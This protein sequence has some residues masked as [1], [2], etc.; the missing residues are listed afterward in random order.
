MAQRKVPLE[1]GRVYHI[2]SKSIAGFT[3]FR[4]N[5]EY[6]RIKYLLTYYNFTDLPWKFSRFFEME[7][8][9]KVHDNYFT[10]MEKLVD[11]IS[12]CIMPT[13]IHL[14]LKNLNQK[15]ISTFMRKILDSYAKYFNIKT[16]RK[17]PLWQSRFE[18]VLVET[19]E[20]LMH[21]TRYVH[22]NPVTAY[23]VDRPENWGFSS[24]K[25]FLDK[26]EEKDKICNYSNV[27]DIK[28]KEYEYFVNSQID[29]QR[30]LAGLKKLWIE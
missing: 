11:I 9:Q 22:L 16:K 26:E 13:H 7:D 14:V 6:Q 10:K 25:E 4:N 23:L 12:Y 17:G 5:S 27:L 15:A 3:I 18:N 1:V 2:F 29:Y 28:P 19:E 21:L 20:Q 24:Y 8:K 30:E